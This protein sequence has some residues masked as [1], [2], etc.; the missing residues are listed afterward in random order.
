MRQLTIRNVSDRVGKK[1]DEL[2]RRSGKSI[3]TLVLEMLDSTLGVKGRAERLRSYVTWSEEEAGEFDRAL[4]TQRQVD[5]GL[6]R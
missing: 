3:N 2:S 5:E 6:W 4:K 1:L